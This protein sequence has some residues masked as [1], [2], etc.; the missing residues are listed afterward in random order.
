MAVGVPPLARLAACP[1]FLVRGRWLGGRVAC[2]V[3]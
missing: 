3:R 1:G 2:E